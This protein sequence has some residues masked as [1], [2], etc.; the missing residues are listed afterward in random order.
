MTECT[1]RRS[2]SIVVPCF[3]E[4][5]VFEL[6]RREL[7]ALAGALAPVYEVELIFVDDGSRDDTWARIRKF[8]SAD[9]RV[10][11]L[12]LSRHFGQQAALTCGYDV[13]EGD[14][15]VCLDADLQ[16]PPE[17]ILQMIEQW[18]KGADVVLGVRERREG[19]TRF[20]R[21]TASLFYRLIRWLGPAQLRADSADFRLMSRRSVLALRRMR[22]QHPFLRGMVGWMG[23]RTAEV[24]Y[25]RR[26][27][28]AGRTKYSLRKMFLLAT[29]AAFSLS[30]A[31]LR[32]ACGLSLAVSLGC[33]A[34]LGYA[35]VAHLAW[36]APLIP[37]WTSLM[38]AVTAFGA[39]IL[40]CLGLLGE[41]VARIYQQGKQRPLYLLQGDTLGDR[42]GG[43]P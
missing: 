7:V 29:D 42:S 16:D 23:F 3:D 8:A 33:L 28:A 39:T 22:E 4:A 36:G 1:S 18:E 10:R 32:L 2:I 17:V 35:V 14:A 6:L 11:G 13:A 30:N 31:P 41:Y 19:E 9:P 25:L 21:W 27:R 26:P 34:Y 37:G 40:L 12:S 15:V 43:A 24:R 20:K 5:E 38:L